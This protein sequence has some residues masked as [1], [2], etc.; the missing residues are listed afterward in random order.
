MVH[1]ETGKRPG[2][3]T[4]PLSTA[5]SPKLVGRER[6]LGFCMASDWPLQ[7]HLKAPEP[8][9]TLKISVELIRTDTF[10]PLLSQQACCLD[11]Q[12]FYN[13]IGHTL[14]NSECFRETPNNFVINCSNMFQQK[15]RAL[16][17]YLPPTRWHRV[18]DTRHVLAS[19]R[20]RSGDR[21]SE[22]AGSEQWAAGSNENL[23]LQDDAGTGRTG[24][25]EIKGQM[26]EMTPHNFKIRNPQSPIRNGPALCSMLPFNPSIR[27]SIPASPRLRVAASSRTAS[28]TPPA[29]G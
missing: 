8:I 2:T 29:A 21:R 26:S 3:Q 22:I 4:R 9:W 16:R 13:L 1:L 10:P 20:Q 19:S 25:M 12:L 23:A 17:T 11:L 24:E 5:V 18:Q 7:Q 6:P 27:N 28:C 15:N 14:S